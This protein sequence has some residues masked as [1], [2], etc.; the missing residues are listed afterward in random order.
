M[1]MR[2]LAAVVVFSGLSGLAM[3]QTVCNSPTNE[4]YGLSVAVGAQCGQA[5]FN[6]AQDLID[7]LETSGLSSLNSSYD[8]SQ[9]ASMNIFFNSL[10][11]SLAFPNSGAT[12]DGA[13][14]V[15]SIPELGINETF[16]GADRDASQNLLEDYL[17]DSGVIADIMKYQAANSPHSPITGPGGAIP[18]AVANDFSETFNTMPAQQEGEAPNLVGAG[19]GFSSLSVDDRDTTVT[20]IPIS[21]AIRNTI[22]PRR[23]L[24]L[25]MPITVSDTEGAKAYA[26]SFGVGYRFPVNEAWTLTP[27]VRYGFTASEDLATVAGVA[28]VSLSSTYALRF[29]AFDMAIG[30]M[31][32][33]YSTTKVSAGDYSFDPDIHNTVLRNGVM[34][35]QPVTLGGKKLAI[36]YSLIDTRY[37]GTEIYVDNT[38]EIGI[39]LGT[40]RSAFSS[41][42]YL[43]G[44][45][46]LLKGKDTTGISLNLGYWF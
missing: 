13:Q 12:G 36:E 21:Y 9:V 31:V 4:L 2:N 34:L 8:G 27:A 30:N 3:A 17:K 11:I 35:S 10:P 29:D 39:T 7:G 40:N 26:L 23:Q 38:Q 28:S 6:T 32:G 44:G 33:Y 1:Q 14:L 20:T 41:R 43:R 19:L 5:S 46:N 22:D 45:L 18:T 37:L 24:V 15:F 25:S 42:S 16:L